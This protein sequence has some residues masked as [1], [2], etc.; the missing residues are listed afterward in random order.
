[1]WIDPVMAQE[2]MTLRD[3]MMLFPQAVGSDD[4]ADAGGNIP[5]ASRRRRQAKFRT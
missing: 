5:D 2:M 4:G 1:V 3:A